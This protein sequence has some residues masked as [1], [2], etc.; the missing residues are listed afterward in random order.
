[1]FKT[2]SKKVMI[3][4]LSCMMMACFPASVSS[5]EEV[6]FELL[7]QSEVVKGK[8]FTSTAQVSG[9]S[10]LAAGVFLVEFDPSLFEFKEASLA[11]GMTGEIKSYCSNGK[12]RV[13]FLNAGGVNANA[14]DLFTIRF[15]ASASLATAVFTAYTEQASTASQASL[16]AGMGQAYSVEI[17]EK[18]SGQTTYASGTKV[19]NTA[20]QNLKNKNKAIENKLADGQDAIESV[21]DYAQNDENS[22]YEIDGKTITGEAG[23]ENMLVIG[24]DSES[25]SKD[26]ALFA[27]GVVI[28]I[29]IVAAG[30]ALFLAG[31]RSAK[32]AVG[33]AKNSTANSDENIVCKTE[34][35][36]TDKAV[37][38][39][40]AEDSTEKAEEAPEKA[41]SKDKKP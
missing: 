28:A 4:L 17:V 33:I 14:A 2:I 15:K 32:A 40:P 29:L 31:K 6:S 8:N 18:S 3:I 21:D 38:N 34:K 5:A 13:V 30:I 41:V 26:L 7:I 1:M 37:D 12:L 23:A 11:Q 22:V 24:N 25:Y 16:P 35:E 27:G 9:T 10:S 20:A 19:T 39:S 36:D